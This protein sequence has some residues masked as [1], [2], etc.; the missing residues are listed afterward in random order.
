MNIIAN[1]NTRSRTTAE[2]FAVGTVAT[3]GLRTVWL[4]LAYFRGIPGYERFHVESAAVLFV[5]VGLA[6]KLVRSRGSHS[7][8]R[9]P[10]SLAGFPLLTWLAFLALA[11]AIYW[12]ALS[13]GFLS[14]DFILANR[15]SKWD[16]GPVTPALLRPVPLFL[17]AVLLRAGGGPS[18]LHLLNVTVHATNAYLTS[19][20]AERWV[21][22]AWSVCASLVVLTAPL[23][24]E[25]VAWCSGVFDVLAMLFVL[26]S[27]LVAR[28]YEDNHTPLT[29]V[30]FLSLTVAAVASKETAAVGVAMV[31][32]DAFVRRA[33]SRELCTDVAVLVSV[34]ALFSLVRLASAFGMTAPSLTKYVLQRAVFGTFG[35]LVVPWH[36]DLTHSMLWLP[37]LGVFFVVCLTLAFFLAE[38]SPRQITLAIAAVTC[39]LLPIIPVWTLF[40]VSADLQGSRYLYLATV[41]WAALIVVFASQ[42]DEST[43][44]RSRS[45]IAV[46]GLLII[47]TFGTVMNLRP[48]KEAAQ[49]RDKVEAA[50]L[51]HASPACERMNL[52]HLPDSIRGAY[53]FRNGVH[54][55]FARDLHLDVMSG[56]ATDGCSFRWDGQN[57]SAITPEP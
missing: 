28:S 54:D 8:A 10:T 14:D 44:V 22:R 1:T 4:S 17:W 35:A 18:A 36:T 6:F 19:R 12:P 3:L 57:M 45:F 43:N 48:W 30:G 47:S 23:G 38:T 5:T 52:R 31:L 9:T 2:F 11:L 15:A 37:T 16:L 56:D 13:I 53:V 29:R 39:L 46:V 34:I 41:G 20:F 21:P 42:H 51:E 24:P 40:F 49:L 27:I 26:L 7:L 50:T 55:A 33:L 25:A 32:V